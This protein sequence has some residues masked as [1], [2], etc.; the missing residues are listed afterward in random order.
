M[1]CGVQGQAKAG[2][3]LQSSTSTAPPSVPMKTKGEEGASLDMH[4]TVSGTAT[5]AMVERSAALR[6]TTTGLV[7]GVGNEMGF[8]VLLVD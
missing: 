8:A 4:V 5:T 6:S 3:D 1:G 7:E 2:C